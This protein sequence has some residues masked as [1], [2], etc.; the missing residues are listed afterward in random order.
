M[1]ESIEGDTDSLRRTQPAGR[2]QDRWF[3]RGH[4]S[5]LVNAKA[6]DPWHLDHD[7]QRATVPA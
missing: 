7:D 6:A 5:T 3:A 4:A 2:S 1:D